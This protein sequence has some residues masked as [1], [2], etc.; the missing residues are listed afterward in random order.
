MLPSLQGR[1][2]K[3]EDR[4]TSPR[5][6]QMLRLSKRTGGQAIA[7]DQ[8]PVWVTSQEPGVSPTRLSDISTPSARAPMRDEQGIRR[9]GLEALK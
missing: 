1:R 2:V 3:D 5:N 6:L 9:S 8:E 4:K 7:T